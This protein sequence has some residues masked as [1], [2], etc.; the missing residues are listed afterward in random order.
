VTVTTETASTD[1]VATAKR[2]AR[3]FRSAGICVLALGIAG[4]GLVYWLGTRA[5]D[6]SDNPDMLG[7]DRNENRQMGILYGKQGE[8]MEEWTNALKEPKNQAGIILGAAVL[9]TIACFKFARLSDRDAE[10]SQS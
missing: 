8:L 1:S 10:M 3:L 9:V 4:A 2:R 5:E 6:L 7:F